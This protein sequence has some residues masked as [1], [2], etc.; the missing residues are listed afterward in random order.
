MIDV[1][2]PRGAIASYTSRWRD[3]DKLLSMTASVLFVLEDLQIAEIGVR[4]DL[5]RAHELAA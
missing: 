5:A 1:L 3:G 4:I 2:A